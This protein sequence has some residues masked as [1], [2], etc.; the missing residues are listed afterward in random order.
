MPTTSKL[1]RD[2][3]AAVDSTDQLT[4][5]LALPEHL[6]DAVWKTAAAEV[7]EHDSPAGLIVAV[8]AG[9]VGFVTLSRAAA[10]TS[11]AEEATG[12]QGSVG[13]ATRG[14]GGGSKPGRV[15]A[16]AEES[17][18]ELAA[19]MKGADMVFLTAGMGGGTG[20]GWS[21]TPAWPLHNPRHGPP[22]AAWCCPVTWARKRTPGPR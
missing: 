3:I 18:R 10:Q 5:V 1:D 4:D 13:G 6:R 19:A 2:Q 11:S 22:R 9:A 21:R 16:A 17:G 20:T 8:M 7:P 15:K 12:P 14:V